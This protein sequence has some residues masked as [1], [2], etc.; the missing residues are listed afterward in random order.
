MEE[1]RSLRSLPRRGGITPQSSSSYSLSHVS[2]ARRSKPTSYVC[3]PKF[4]PK[5]IKKAATPSCAVLHLQY[6]LLNLPRRNP[7]AT[8][9]FILGFNCGRS[10]RVLGEEQ[11]KRYASPRILYMH[12]FFQHVLASLGCN[13]SRSILGGGWLFCKNKRQSGLMKLV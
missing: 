2:Y 10:Q 7:S 5:E 1:S 13:S 3:T 12:R 9:V 8:Y 6:D 11:A 4:S